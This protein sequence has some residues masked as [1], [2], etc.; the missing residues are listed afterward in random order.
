MLFFSPSRFFVFDCAT[1]ASGEFN[2][3]SPRGGDGGDAARQWEKMLLSERSLKRLT[4]DIESAVGVLGG[5]RFQPAQAQ[6]TI[7]LR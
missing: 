6:L 4:N 7:T 2:R 3:R 5:Q 1:V